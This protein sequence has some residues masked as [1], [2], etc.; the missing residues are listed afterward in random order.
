MVIRCAWATSD[1]LYLD[2]HDHEWGRPVHGDDKIYERVTLE[3]F[4]SG[5]AWITILRKRRTSGR[6]ST[7]S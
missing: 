6:P 5:L 4:Q 2:Y 1:P 3:A 7:G